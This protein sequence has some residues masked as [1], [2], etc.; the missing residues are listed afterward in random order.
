MKK[1]TNTKKS[2]STRAEC[3]IGA[4]G[5]IT[6]SITEIGWIEKTLRAL[7]EIGHAFIAKASD[8]EIADALS[9]RLGVT[10]KDALDRLKWID[11]NKPGGVTTRY[12]GTVASTANGV[13]H[14]PRLEE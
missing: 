11:L 7:D 4:G 13:S 9:R 5:K 12:I 2:K 3:P 8:R 6:M 1:K 10:A 14:E